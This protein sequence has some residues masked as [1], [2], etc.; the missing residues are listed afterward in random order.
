MIRRERALRQLAARYPG[1]HLERR[2]KGWRLVGPR[3]EIVAAAWTPS[4]AGFL[5]VVESTI[6]R[7]ERQ[8]DSRAG[9]CGPGPVNPAG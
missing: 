1:W 4:D 7:A 6:R 2:R 5:H 3:G 8:R 9:A